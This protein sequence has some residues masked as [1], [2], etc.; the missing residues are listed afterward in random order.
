MMHDDGFS[1]WPFTSNQCIDKLALAQA[2]NPSLSYNLE[3]ISLS[4]ETFAVE[5]CKGVCL[6]ENRELLSSVAASLDTVSNRHLLDAITTS[7]R[8]TQT[9]SDV[10]RVAL[11]LP[12][13]LDNIER[14]N[15]L[16]ALLPKQPLQDLFD[17]YVLY[18]IT[19]GFTNQ[20]DDWSKYFFSYKKKYAWDDFNRLQL[21]YGLAILSRSEESIRQLRTSLINSFEAYT[22]SN[23]LI[24]SIEINQTARSRLNW[25]ILYGSA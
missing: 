17:A 5:H 13:T 9:I 1:Y 14:A 3:W 19:F 4:V 2:N 7:E 10:L 8:S 20:L 15:R 12:Y 21:D 22:K 18:Q 23:Y 25:L 24:N 11:C 16:Y 6:S